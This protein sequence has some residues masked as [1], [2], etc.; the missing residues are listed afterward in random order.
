MLM[1][2]R[3]AGTH[4][5]ADVSFGIDVTL[6]EAP[7]PRRRSR[8]GTT[9]ASVPEESPSARQKPGEAQLPT[10]GAATPAAIVGSELEG[11]NTG[12][13][14]SLQSPSTLYHPPTTT[15]STRSSGPA[16]SEGLPYWKSL[17]PGSTSAGRLSSPL[18]RTRLSTSREKDV[19][20]PNDEDQEEEDGGVVVVGARPKL[21][22][23]RVQTT[24]AAGTETAQSRRSI[25]PR[26]EEV[27]A[28]D[29]S[30]PVP[31]GR[32][33]GIQNPVVSGP[34]AGRED[35]QEQQIVQDAVEKRPPTMR[36]PGR[37]R[38]S[39]VTQPIAEES[40]QETS[41]IGKPSRER[42]GLSSSVIMSEDDEEQ[43]EEEES[44][45]MGDVLERSQQRRGVTGSSAQSRSQTAGK[46][47]RRS[48]ASREH[49]HQRKPN[50]PT[51]ARP[52]GSARQA[53]DRET[54]PILVHRLS[55]HHS[56]DYDG[57]D[58]VFN[59][60][61]PNSNRAGVNAVDV[62]SQI[63]REL[64]AGSV[65]KLRQGAEQE[66]D[67]TRLREWNR[68]RKAVEAFGEELEERL[69]DMTEVLDYNYIL[70]VKL[71]KANKEKFSLRE[72]LLQVR[73]ARE[74]MALRMD[75]IRRKHEESGKAAENRNALNTAF[76][77][78]EVAVERGRARQQKHGPHDGDANELSGLEARIMNV[79][80]DVSST[81][82]TGS[83][84][85]RVKEFNVFLERAA[86]VLEGRL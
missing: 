46:V 58:A 65:E 1:R 48:P 67:D 61:P 68:K 10:G 22:M 44:E 2:Q 12:G 19:L 11:Q 9:P 27:E 56:G 40:P 74:V 14:T 23:G 76:H 35:K 4:K 39:N 45:R 3:G 86:A 62:L 37:P 77:D 53:L 47:R 82:D 20:D 50:V 73:Q 51:R 5:L 78:I 55:T 52:K 66:D 83:L 34:K 8:R 32:K 16:T 80:A 60:N 25:K 18:L 41:G 64:I 6:P 15:R 17:S 36:R 57:E 72:R 63:C 84:L 26:I 59:P 85:G 79:A 28:P 24:D 30:P 33:K 75:Q 7:T 54:V 69:F 81:S 21:G 43:E 70:T 29:S 49:V 42:E 38:K 31:K 71:R 13:P